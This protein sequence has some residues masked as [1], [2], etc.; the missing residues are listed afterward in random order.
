[1][2]SNLE[3]HTQPNYQKKH[4]DRIKTFSDTKVSRLYF[5][6]R[7]AQERERCN[8]SRS[9][10]TGEVL[11]KRGISRRMVEKHGGQQPGWV[12]HQWRDRRVGRCPDLLYRLLNS[13]TECSGELGRY[14]L[15]CAVL[16]SL[17]AG[18][19]SIS[20]PTGALCGDALLRAKAGRGELRRAI[21]RAVHFPWQFPFLQEGHRSLYAQE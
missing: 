9:F 17:L 3:F 8:R 2:L 6:C 19:M 15:P 21:H 10:N 16:C 14:S 20:P 5:P 7:L 4:K 11:K 13:W 1:M 18:W 12:H